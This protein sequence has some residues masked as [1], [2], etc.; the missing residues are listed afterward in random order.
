LDL[1][2]YMVLVI[3]REAG[4]RGYACITTEL[5]NEARRRHETAPT[6]TVV[7][8]RA[9]T[10]GSLMGG[11]LKVRQR[12]AIKWEGS[13]PLLKTI[14]EADSNGTVRGYTAGVD[15]DLRD[16][17]GEHDI[18]RAIGRAGLLTV[19]R[20]LQLKELAESAVPLATSDMDGDLTYYLEQS[21]QIPSIVST[22]A[23]L[24]DE[25]GVAVSGGLLIQP[26]PPYDPATVEQLRDRLLEMPPL[27]ELLK[28]GL[29]PEGVL[30]QAFMGLGHK[31]LS[32]YPLRFRCNCSRERTRRALLMLGR[33]GLADML[34]SEGEAIVDCHY[35]R[36]RYVFGREEL[37]TLIEELT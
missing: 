37:E 27:G 28:S 10:A 22:A 7:L 13:G 21:D 1:K 6:A 15:V 17:H 8:A 12:V 23:V 11:L 26:L 32:K 35:C 16:S 4:L 5:A 9:L 3:A 31:L 24:N 33:E 19:V 25:G 14:V 30:D 2:D 29:K 18:V 36:E 34:A 20:D